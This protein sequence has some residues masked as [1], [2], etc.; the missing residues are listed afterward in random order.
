ME[1]RLQSN[2]LVHTPGFISYA[3]NVWRTQPSLAIDLLSA[4][5][6]LPAWA[7]PQLLSGSYEKDGDTIVIKKDR[8]NKTPLCDLEQ[9][10]PGT[11]RRTR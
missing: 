10:R 4:Y 3:A 1:I 6:D 5:D 7:I 9:V 11:R 2:S 8:D